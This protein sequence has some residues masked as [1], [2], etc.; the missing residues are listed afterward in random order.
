M[1]PRFQSILVPVDF[2]DKN[3]SALDIAFET[4]VHNKA[5][6][7]LLHVI[8]VIDDG[9][10]GDDPDVK[11]FYRRLEERSRRELETMGQR[12]DDAGVAIHEKVR[13]GKRAVEI[14]N[15]SNEHSDDLIV[16]SS[17]PLA[18]RNP[19]TSIVTLSY[20]VTLICECPV[21][22]VK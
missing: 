6:V 9:D 21:L 14:V 18:E 5:T 1:I 10:F 22:L 17:H 2:T 20:Q 3:W 4:A 15:Y 7:T 19:S 12:F 8:E 16:M 11:E 13:F